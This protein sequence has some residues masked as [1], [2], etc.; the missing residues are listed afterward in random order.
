MIRPSKEHK[1]VSHKGLCN[2]QNWSLTLSQRSLKAKWQA[3]MYFSI[4]GESKHTLSLE[5]TKCV[6]NCALKH[7][8]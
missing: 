1:Y 8:F 5:E 7:I 2:R 3:S 6:L 4:S